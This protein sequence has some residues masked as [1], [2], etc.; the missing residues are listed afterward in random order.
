MSKNLAVC[1]DFGGNNPSLVTFKMLLLD[2][3]QPFGIEAITVSETNYKKDDLIL[4]FI[5]EMDDGNVDAVHQAIENVIT[6][7]GGNYHYPDNN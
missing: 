6:S 7:L 1:G 4:I 2:E 3:L 5:G